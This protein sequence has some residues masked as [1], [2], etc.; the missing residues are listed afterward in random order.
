[1]KR[2]YL[3]PKFRGK[4]IGRTLAEFII[5]QGATLVTKKCG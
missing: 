4:G 5:S 3:R 1:M 2:L